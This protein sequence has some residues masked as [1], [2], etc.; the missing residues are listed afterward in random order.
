MTLRQLFY[1]TVSAGKLPST[2]AAHYRRLGAVMT[3]LRE[4]GVVPLDW[5]V[6]S[7]RATYK[8]SSWSGLGDFGETVRDRYRRDFWRDQHIAIHAVCEKDAVA[9][10][11]Q[12]VTAEYDV[13]LHVLR[14][15]PS[16]SFAGTI[17][18]E[19]RRTRKPI[20]CFY[21][22]DFDPSGF[23]IERD[24]RAKLERWSGKR[25]DGR[26][27]EWRRL[28]VVAADF[29]AFDLLPLPV[30]ASDVRAQAFARTHGTRCAEIDALPPTELRRRVREAIEETI[31][32]DEWERLRTI[33]AAERETLDTVTRTWG[34]SDVT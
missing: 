1:R 13:P 27:M 22:G 3:R 26:A 12:P 4:R 18:A 25:F 17:A 15:Y 29:E 2:D 16:L 24:A 28:G 31:D 23:D 9:G 32:R 20:A 19:M 14:G 8:P 6:D 21:V 10:T 30:K 33:E 34:A 7:L 11:I 5:L